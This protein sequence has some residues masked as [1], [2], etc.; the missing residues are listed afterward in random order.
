MRGCG[1]V[2]TRMV[3]IHY[4]MSDMKH[5]HTPLPSPNIEDELLTYDPFLPCIWDGVHPGGR[6]PS[7]S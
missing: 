5:Q 2:P 1:L 3:Y 4:S 7:C 6:T